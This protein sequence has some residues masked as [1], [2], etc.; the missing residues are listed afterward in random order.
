VRVA[1]V[2]ADPNRASELIGAVEYLLALVDELCDFN[3]GNLLLGQGQ[4]LVDVALRPARRCALASSLE[5]IV[6]RR[7]YRGFFSKIWRVLRINNPVRRSLRVLRQQSPSIAAGSIGSHSRSKQRLGGPAMKSVYVSAAAFALTAAVNLSPAL[8]EGQKLSGGNA[9]PGMSQP[10]TT[11]S[12]AAVTGFSSGNR[13]PAQTMCVHASA[14]DKCST[15][16]LGK[17]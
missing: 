7:V 15:A 3:V 10:L 2:A 14:S 17:Q 11:P 5:E 6:R 13:R 4:P 16:G 9:W 12:S 8:A 1:H